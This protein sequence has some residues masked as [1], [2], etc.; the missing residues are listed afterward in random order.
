MSSFLSGPSVKQ[1]IWDHV[2]KPVYGTILLLFLIPVNDDRT[3]FYLAFAPSVLV[4]L[5]AAC[6]ALNWLGLHHATTPVA[7]LV[8]YH[9]LHSAITT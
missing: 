4:T 7:K 1:P 9:H 8:Y 3:S 2:I 6:M 5:L